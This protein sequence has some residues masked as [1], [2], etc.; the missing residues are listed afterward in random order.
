[1]KQQKRDV[2]EHFNAGMLLV[3][4]IEVEANEEQENR[5]DSAKWGISHRFAVELARNPTWLQVLD[6]DKD[7]VVSEED[8][9]HLRAEDAREIYRVEFWER[10][11]CGDL[12]YPLG[13]M[14]FG[15]VVH[16]APPE[17][18]RMLQRAIN[19]TAAR[20]VVNV[21]GQMGSDTLAWAN[22]LDVTELCKQLDTEASSRYTEARRSRRFGVEGLQY[23]NT[24]AL[25]FEAV[26]RAS[27]AYG[28]DEET[29]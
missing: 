26:E 8:L 14:F 27:R 16:L 22:R 9:K 18:Q 21:T 4:G 12:P 5:E 11:R 29:S 17:P 23:R 7:G 24:G 10:H 15:Y 25:W 6:A 19:R 2:L 1:M 20:N 3:F 13:A 28:G